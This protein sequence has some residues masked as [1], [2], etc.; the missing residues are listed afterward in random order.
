MAGQRSE[1]QSELSRLANQLKHTQ[2]VKDD[3]LTN[4]GIQNAQLA[5]AGLDHLASVKQYN[6]FL[7]PAGASTS[8]SGNSTPACATTPACRALSAQI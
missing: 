8:L 7:A 1:W 3:L 2:T 5:K 4:N 6:D